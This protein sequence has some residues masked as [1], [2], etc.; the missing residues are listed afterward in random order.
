MLQII[1]N[2]MLAGVPGKVGRNDMLHITL[3][4]MQMCNIGL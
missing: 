2:L 3:E 1:Q 4:S